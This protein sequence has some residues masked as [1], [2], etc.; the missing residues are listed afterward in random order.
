MKRSAKKLK[1]DRLTLAP[2]TLALARGGIPLSVEEC[3]SSQILSH[4]PTN[5]PN[6]GPTWNC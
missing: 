1:L 6:C 2:L 5:C 3:S 4:A